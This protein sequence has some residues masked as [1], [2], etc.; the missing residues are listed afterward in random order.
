MVGGP[1]TF[2][3]EQVG[4]V[5]LCGCGS[6]CSSGRCI[7]GADG[8][9]GRARRQ[10]TVVS[11]AKEAA[12]ELEHRCGGVLALPR[13]A[14]ARVR[15]RV[16]VGKER[17]RL[18]ASS[19]PRPSHQHVKVWRRGAGDGRLRHVQVGH[20]VPY[21]C[22]RPP[23]RVGPARP[24]LVAAAAAKAGRRR[25]S[26]SSPSA[27]SAGMALLA[28]ATAPVYMH[29]FPTQPVNDWDHGLMV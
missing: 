21:L 26:Y 3:E 24:V 14:R 9:K 16:G 22:V 23:A 12:V 5:G 2:W 10:R 18:P 19:A 17:E 20:Y 15:A 1:G 11:A 7:W 29:Y 6:Q 4:P 25:T 27:A 28:M 13:C 8:R